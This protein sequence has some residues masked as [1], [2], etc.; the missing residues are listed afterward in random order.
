MWP[1]YFWFCRGMCNIDSCKTDL[2]FCNLL[3]SYNPE[4]SYGY[5]LFYNLGLH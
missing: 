1:F 2:T 5:K 4:N 3:V